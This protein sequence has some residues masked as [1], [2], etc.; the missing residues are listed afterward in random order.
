MSVVCYIGRNGFLWEQ[1]LSDQTFSYWH[2]NL[3]ISQGLFMIKKNWYCLIGLLVE[4]TFRGGGNPIVSIS[5]W[6]NARFSVWET[7]LEET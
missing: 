5:R 7:S 1:I 6:Q 3:S 2:N 4:N